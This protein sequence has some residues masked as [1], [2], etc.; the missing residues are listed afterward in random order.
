MHCNAAL[1]LFSGSLYTGMKINRKEVRVFC[2]ARDR[3]LSR[4]WDEN[5][6]AAK[7]HEPVVGTIVINLIII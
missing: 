4:A 2:T 5:S 3:K 1:A 6:L 7:F